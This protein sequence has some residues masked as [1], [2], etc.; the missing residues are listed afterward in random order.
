MNS[1]INSKRWS[2]VKT[3]TD[4]QKAK[5][6]ALMDCTPWMKGNLKV[7]SIKRHQDKLW[8]KTKWKEIKRTLQFSNK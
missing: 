4:D 7:D 1:A 6:Q 2:E 3:F 5:F 8:A